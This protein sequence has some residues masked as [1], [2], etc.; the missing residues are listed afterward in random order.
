M[1]AIEGKLA[2]QKIR[3]YIQ[4]PTEPH[5]G[6]LLWHENEEVKALCRM[7]DDL[8]REIEEDLPFLD[9]K[10]RATVSEAIYQYCRP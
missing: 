8:E 2:I 4:Q 6:I 9:N 1:T 7:L 3:E 10:R 5:G